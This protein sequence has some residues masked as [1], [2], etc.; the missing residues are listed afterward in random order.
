MSKHKSTKT[1]IG[2]SSCL[3]G[4]KVR[5]D[6]QDRKDDHVLKLCEQFHCIAICPEYAIGLGVPRAPIK[7]IQFDSGKRVRGAENQKLDVTDPLMEYADSIYE[8]I[9]HLCGYIFKARSPSCGVNSTPYF[10]ENGTDLGVT[11]GVYSNR[12]QQQFHNL[13]VIEDSELKTDNDIQGFIDAVN[14]YAKE[15]I[16]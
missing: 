14:N 16:A 15:H 13:P 9:P 7:I 2:V 11:S 3:L 8:S 12:I 4:Y 10:S 1:K 5:Y 6:G